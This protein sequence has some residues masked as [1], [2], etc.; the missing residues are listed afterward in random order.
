M[1]EGLFE[2]EGWV[3]LGSFLPEA[4]DTAVAEDTDCLDFGTC[5]VLGCIHRSFASHSVAVDSPFQI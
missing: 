2:V 3:F 1:S 5:T 4:F